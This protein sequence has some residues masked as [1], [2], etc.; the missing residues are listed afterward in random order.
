MAEETKHGKARQAFEQLDIGEKI[1][2]AELAKKV[3]AT[4]SAERKNVGAFLSQLAKRGRAQKNV[5][6]DGR[7]YYEKIA[8]T[9]RPR[10]PRAAPSKDR[11]KDEV[12][13][14]EI[15]ES[16]VDYIQKL[17]SRIADLEAQKEEFKRLYEEA[18][19]KVK[20]LSE[21]QSAEQKTIRL[22]KLIEDSS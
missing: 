8:P 14:G 17:R 15:G 13:L 1:S 4:T 16:I 2:A 11:R 6:E 21:S 19:Q 22:S 10:T 5:G 18:E 12:T 3:G 20:D 7:M 9:A